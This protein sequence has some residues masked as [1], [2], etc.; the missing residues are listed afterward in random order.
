[1]AQI[2]DQ[3]G[4]VIIVPDGT[5]PEQLE[6]MLKERN[7]A[8]TAAEEMEKLPAVGD[9]FYGKQ[10]PDF[11]QGKIERFSP[12]QNTPL[13]MT[14]SPVETTI[15]V[16]SGTTMF[17]D[18]KP[19]KL[20]NDNARDFDNDLAMAN[21]ILDFDDLPEWVEQVPEWGN[22]KILFIALN[23]EEKA[24][25]NKRNLNYSTGEIDLK[26]MQ[27]DTIIMAARNPK[28]RKH[29][30]AQSMKDKLLK[31]NGTVI[32]RLFARIQVKSG[33]TEQSRE[34]VRKNSN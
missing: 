12:G 4:K 34:M 16:R 8:I 18:V 13:P 24:A 17:E 29:F 2:T 3:N 25:I 19:A 23:G 7:A 28:T 14:D 30:L 20:N 6:K 15:T 1:M 27:A 5:T 9:P 21:A 32:E 22:V 26:G 10:V 31:K 11:M 33:T